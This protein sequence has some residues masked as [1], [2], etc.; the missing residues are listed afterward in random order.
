M[1]SGINV[2]VMEVNKQDLTEREIV[3]QTRLDE[4]WV[5]WS[6]DYL[7]N[8]PPALKEFVPRCN[9]KVGSL[10]LIREDNFSRMKWPLG[11]VVET[12]SGND[13]VV[14]SVKLKTLKGMV[15]RDVQ[16]L[17]DLEISDAESSQAK[18]EALQDVDGKGL[19]E[20]G[21]HVVTRAGRVIKPVIRMNL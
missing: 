20:K 10:V 1:P 9:L 16:K 12:F 13:G 11:V 7:R 19:S 17:H 3:R 18:N 2:E 4:F 21:S 15:T 5:V 6:K 8:L 14:R